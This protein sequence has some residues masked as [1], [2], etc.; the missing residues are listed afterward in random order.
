MQIFWAIA[1]AVAAVAFGASS[2]IVPDF[3]G[4]EPNQ[5]PVPQNDPPVQPA[6][7]AFAIWAVIYLWLV[8]SAGYGLLRRATAP[9][10]EPMRPALALSL[11]VGATWLPIA[12]ASPLAAALLIWVM[13][14][15]ALAALLRAPLLDRWWARA[16]LGLYA[17]W[18]SAASCV[19]LGLILAGYGLM[20]ERAAALLCL[21]LAIVLA[22]TVQILI[23]GVPE[24]GLAVI[25]ALLGVVVANIGGIGMVFVLA[26]LGIVV[27][28]VLCLRA[29]TLPRA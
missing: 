28:A 29:L 9:D 13:L 27:M 1:V 4:F 14:A 26:L 19:A 16:P 11:A 17:G 18:L 10:W 12:K 22:A 23:E 25:W 5:F 21:T 8:A 20:E 24:Y 3:G 2:Y 6:G 7:Y 15:A